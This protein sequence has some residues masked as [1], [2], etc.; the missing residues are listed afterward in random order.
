MPSGAVYVGRGSKWGNPFTFA[1]S[2]T[3]HPAIRFACEVAP[4]LDVT[5]LRGKDL[6]CWCKL[7]AECHA[8][9]LLDLANS[10]R[11]LATSE[12][13][14]EIG[15]PAD[16][17]R[18]WKSRG[19]L[20]LAP[21]GVAGQGRGI[22]CNWSAEAVEQARRIASTRKPGPPRTRCIPTSDR[23]ETK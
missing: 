14:N 12:V 9:V 23:V 1:N 2:G 22:E 20:S 3:V 10:S 17:L 8:D 5:P 19:L 18:K 7:D 6:A 21:Q 15:V 13:A 16:L 4:L 11:E